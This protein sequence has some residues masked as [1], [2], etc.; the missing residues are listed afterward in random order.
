MASSERSISHQFAAVAASAGLN[1]IAA[2]DARS[3]DLLLLPGAVLVEAS[4]QSAIAFDVSLK[5]GPPL[6]E[7]AAYAV[8]A[9]FTA[10]MNVIAQLVRPW[11]LTSAISPSCSAQ[12]YAHPFPVRPIVCSVPTRMGS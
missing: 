9:E 10:E 8:S 11:L 1:K 4:A 2:L 6:Q 3:N 12:S 7:R 5:D